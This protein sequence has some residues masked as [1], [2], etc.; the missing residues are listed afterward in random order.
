MQM[1]RTRF[2]R[3]QQSAVVLQRIT[4]GYLQRASYLRQ[5][6]ACLTIQNYWR[7]WRCMRAERAS[8]LKAKNA[9]TCIQSWWRAHC[10]R[11]RYES[12][13]YATI[14]LQRH[15]RGFFARR[16]A[17]RRRAA[18]SLLQV[19]LRG[20]L[21]MKRDRA[22]YLLQLRAV[23]RLQTAGRAVLARQRHKR[24]LE[25]AE[26]REEVRR[27]EEARAAARKG[28]AAT[29]LVRAVRRYLVRR[30]VVKRVRATVVI[31]KYWRGYR[32][33]IDIR[34]QWCALTERLDEIRDRLIVV[35]A[36]AKPEDR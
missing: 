29:V 2:L 31:Q 18:V 24:L 20:Y 25:D 32:S 19:T 3:L 36:E 35:N 21:A 27:Q 12:L 26:Y 9:A 34:K 6:S 13:R 5:R 10:A 33:R 4:R 1:N 7:S 15:V 16:L 8:F 28:E 11:V 14:L 22:A 30:R 23:L 17:S